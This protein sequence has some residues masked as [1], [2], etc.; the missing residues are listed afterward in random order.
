MLAGVSTWAVVLLLDGPA[1]W[2]ADP[3]A[4][5]GA[6]DALGALPREL[7][8]RLT[9]A[10]DVV[11]VGN[12]KVA[13]DLNLPVLTASMSRL[14]RAAAPRFA[15]LGV[16]GTQAPVW[17]A[18]ASE[19]V[20]GSGARPRALLAY[21]TLTGALTTV[22]PLAPARTQLARLLGPGAPPS[23]ARPFGGALTPE[24][25]EA[26][27]K[28][29]G[30]LCDP[31]RRQAPALSAPVA[32]L[33]VEASFLAELA[34]LAAHHGARFG[35]VRQPVAPS[36]NLDDTVSPE[37]E[38]AA[39]ALVRR[40]GGVWIDLRNAL[41]SELL[42]GDGVHMSEA[43]RHQATRA[44]AEALVGLG[45]WLE[46]PPPFP[47]E[48]TVAPSPPAW[49]TPPAAPEGAWS[50][51]G[52]CAATWTLPPALAAVAPE[53]LAR[54]G[55]AG[56]SPLQLLRWRRPVAQD[57]ARARCTDGWKEAGGVVTATFERDK[58]SGLKLAWTADAE[59][60]GGAGR[61]GWW[62]AP[63]APLRFGAMPG[64]V[65]ISGWSP[66]GVRLTAGSQ[67]FALPGD[68]FSVS[69]DAAELTTVAV[70]GGWALVT[71][72]GAHV[73]PA[74]RTLDLR[75]AALE[76][77]T[78]P[79]LDAVELKQARRK[80]WTAGAEVPAVADLGADRV[81]VASGLGGCSPVVAEGWQLSVAGGR[82]N[83]ARPDCGEVEPETRLQLTL[84]EDRACNGGGG[85]WLY[86]GDHQEWRL[87]DPKA[88]RGPWTL[89]LGA[90]AIGGEEGARI[91]VQVD[92][93]AGSLLNT[94][95]LASELRRKG[96][97]WP[98]TRA[99]GPGLRVTV[100][101]PVSAP[102]VLFGRAALVEGL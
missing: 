50:P 23:L 38:R 79:R 64:K 57:A 63:D 94:S 70:E 19:H 53:A 35:F 26:Y 72:A 98:L 44:L 54:A 48:P 41:G 102:W 36:G 20:F 4:Q 84:R 46:R 11:F 18:V 43:G 28:A 55:F 71:R 87:A 62:V 1:A 73:A 2:A 85:R 95:F 39:M 52:E 68:R 3:P 40:G 22:L 66:P 25:L 101:S 91:E 42:Y 16:P 59:A 97:R 6:A 13:T 75:A 90:G 83:V 61:H 7:R 67:S 58:R 78:A 93:D 99:P 29:G 74:T 17:Y 77:G 56:A 86:P 34:A 27:V 12:S 33:P 82:V 9:P 45:D 88:G 31:E 15:G 49:V 69:V 32:P 24:L 8:A 21:G 89:E 51:V 65:E 10:P 60:R 37:E 30:N 81:N 14:Q 80:P 5:E 92:D 100:V 47:A 96:Q 76:V